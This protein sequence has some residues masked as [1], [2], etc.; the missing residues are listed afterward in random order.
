MRNGAQ[1]IFDVNSFRCW[2]LRGW[3]FCLHRAL[4]RQQIQ[5]VLDL[6]AQHGVGNVVYTLDGPL[7]EAYFNLIGGRVKLDAQQFDGVL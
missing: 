4:G 5:Q 2:R 6:A 1:F 3:R 7:C